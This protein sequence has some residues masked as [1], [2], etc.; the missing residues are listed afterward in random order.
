MGWPTNAADWVTKVKD[1]LDSDDLEDT[2][3]IAFLDIGNARLNRECNSQYMEK[4]LGVTFPASGATVAVPSDFNRMRAIYT[5]TLAPLRALRID[6]MLQFISTNPTGASSAYSINENKIDIEPPPAADKAFQLRY[7]IKVPDLKSGTTESNVFTI[8]HP[9]L[10]L[11][12]ALLAA[13]PYIIE[14]ERVPIWQGLYK[15]ALD[16]VNANAQLAKDGASPKTAMGYPTDYA[17]W[18]NLLKDWI[19]IDTLPDSALG[20]FLSL[21][22]TR[23]NR[24][25]MSFR[26]EARVSIV[27]PTTGVINIS[28]FDPYFGKMI[29]MYRTVSSSTLRFLDVNAYYAFRANYSGNSSGVAVVYTIEN[30]QLR[31]FPI[32][33]SDTTYFVL[34]YRR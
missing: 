8:N 4:Q 32:P 1:W 17:G 5:G 22:N 33:T 30:E 12:A 26:N 15:Q 2:Q 19:K 25:I 10:F 13:E 29:S 21:A 20:T 14:D 24:D 31:I 27:I 34:Y 16:T 11:Y 6:E 3:I 23:L 28:S 18:K 7:Y 9:D